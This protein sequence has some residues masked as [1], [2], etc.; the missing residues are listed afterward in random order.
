[1]LNL[2]P[3]KARLAASGSLRQGYAWTG[4]THGIVFARKPGD[5]AT[6]IARGI[7]FSGD[8][9][10]IANAP[11]DLAAL[12]AEVERL[13]ARVAELEA[14]DDSSEALDDAIWEG[15]FGSVPTSV[16][17]GVM[18]A[19]HDYYEGP[20]RVI[21]RRDRYDELLRALDA[22]VSDNEGVPRA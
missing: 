4:G 7:E 17:D 22:I 18:D 20:G 10:L 11:A 3:I 14:D 13:R 16:V 2:D 6:T 5:A 19:I 1:M 21:I 9:A 15:C 12:V 8:T